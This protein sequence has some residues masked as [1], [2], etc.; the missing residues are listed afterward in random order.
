[1]INKNKI[2]ML[3]KIFT[4]VLIPLSILALKAQNGTIKGIISDAKSKE[5]IIGV[6]VMLQGTNKGVQTDIDGSFTLEN[7]AAGT[8]NLQISYVSYTSKTVPV[9]VSENQTTNLGAI[10]MEEE[11]KV[12]AEVIVKGI[13]KTNTENAVLIETKK[14]EQ[15]AV[16]VSA[17]QIAKTQDRDAS[18]V[19]RRVPGVSIMDERFVMIR[20]LN[21]RYNTVLLNDAITPSTEVDVR[22]F[23]FDLIP[24]NAIDRMLI[25]KTAS[26]ENSG[27]MAGGIVKIYT[28][29]RP[30]VN[31]V[32]F[33]LS[34]GYRGDVT[35]RDILSSKGG[36]LDAVGVDDGSRAL[37]KD[38]ASRSVLNGS[39]RDVANAQFK[40]LAPFFSLKNKMISPDVRANFGL[41]R[42]MDIGDVK[43][44]NITNINY[45]MS[46]TLPQNNIQERF[47]GINNNEIAL[48]WADLTYANNVRLGAMSNFNMATGKSK[49]EF[50]N[51]FNQT[52]INETLVREGVNENEQLAFKNYAFRYETRTIYS[53][54]FNATHD[55]SEKS[56]LSWT[57][58][59][60]F[61]NRYEPDYRRL[62]TSRAVGLTDQ[63]YKVD[64]PTASNPSLTQAARFW[65]A[66]NEHSVSGAA[67][68]EHKILTN[69]REL[70]LRAGVFVE[71][72]TRDFN[73]RW[74]GYVN[75]KNS[76]IVKQTPSVF[77]NNENIT[78]NAG[79]VSMLEGTNF[80]DAYQAQNLL[81]AA[82]ASIYVPFSQKF[83]ATFGFR[84]EMNRQ[85]LQSRLRGS[86]E[87]VGVDNP[88]FSPLPSVN[89]TYDLT[90]KQKLRFA[91]GMTVNRP[92]FRELAPFSYY[93]FGLG[94]SKTGNPN[95]KTATIHN[96]DVRYE[97]YP[98]EGELI[99]VAGFYKYFI[100]PIE[101][102]GRSAG[103]GTAFFY[104]NPKSAITTG[105]EVEM[106]KQLSGIL[107]DK[108]TLVANASVIYSKVDA[109]NLEG[110]IEN[111]PLQGQ[112][113][114]LINAGLY[115]NGDLFQM[116]VLYN[117]VGKR[118]FVAGDKLGNQTIYEMPRNVLDINITKTF[119]KFI[120]VRMGISDLL[121]QSFRF[122][123][124][125]NND[126]KIDANDLNWRSF[127]RGTQA[128][129]GVNFKF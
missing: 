110:Q 122:T 33:G 34:V 116:N 113:P 55:F 48:R 124:D 27:E 107:D 21:E 11:T 32:S 109:S 42:I 126:T 127:N 119:G 93:D 44:S 45:S 71:N 90:E 88:I 112:S 12:M 69:E 91:Y 111:R 24:S 73:A 61:T 106:R 39:N 59:Y 75:P 1:M 31:Q 128:T 81:T 77:F 22:S 74:F 114:Y 41:S 37:P 8:H 14:L 84:G 62:T 43:L 129:L 4:L 65:S 38:F 103:S 29:T 117:V 99:T 23:S 19:I 40:S 5:S 57:V 30:E 68:Y 20:G 87:K 85:Q 120:E 51:L 25:F 28:K 72:K 83:N 66:L 95:L 18:Q 79:G 46:N 15:I 115:Y 3:R 60:G 10:I 49:F 118:I 100:N 53:G 36:A 67:N 98:N 26:A 82:Y 52:A 92:E 123:T 6:V 102:S 47:E 121:N 13:K 89:M 64:V 96:A 97:I 17:Q 125:T 54:Q 94:L 50:R 16:G 86:G 104:S 35:G 56:K 58:G 105:V 2:I 78:S 7:V 76:D 80:D 108:L 63:D 70:K 101:M 9:V